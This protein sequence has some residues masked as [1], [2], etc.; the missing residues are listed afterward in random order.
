MKV[1]VIAARIL[2]GAIFIYSGFV[3]GI[4]PWGSTYKFIDYFTAFNMSWM[5]PA[6]FT[7]AVLQNTLEFVIGVALTLG[8]RMKET[9]WTALLFMGF[10]TILTFI[11]ALTN[12]VSDCGCFGDALILTNWQTFYKNL[13]LMALA[14]TVFS[15]RKKY[16]P[17]YSPTGEWIWVTMITV[18]I[19][20]IS[21]HCYQHLPWIDFRPYRIGADIPKGMTVPEG[22]PA[23]EY[24]S[25]VI[26]EKD[27]VTR[28]FP[29]NDYPWDDSTWIYKDTRTVLVKKGYT[30]PIHDFSI[31]TADGDDITDEVLADEG[32][33]FLLVAHRLNRSNRQGLDKASDIA[34]F[35]N[36]HGYRFYCLTASPQSEIEP[37]K[38]ELGLKYNFCFTDEITLKTIV[39]ANPGL[40]LLQK[41][42]VVDKW[43]YND[44]P[45]GVSLK[46]NLLSS[47]L[48]RQVAKSGNRLNNGLL[49]AVIFFAFVFFHFRHPE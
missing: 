14:I 17:A 33:T 41:G 49:V 36:E 28:E 35:C 25:T 30:P 18:V 24:H 10:Y 31:T 2:L 21:I 5:Q 39:R 47:S 42:T 44:M 12:P 11:L 9:G 23:D 20:G 15:Y 27:G 1:L 32:Y 3:K 37:L 34:D 45:D 4:D 48:D 38:A 22:E 29:V 8:L 40:V 46:P 26:L 7:L 13:V 43:H 16:L 19:V 6:A